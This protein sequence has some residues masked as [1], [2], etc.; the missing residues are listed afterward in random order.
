[1]ENFQSLLFQTSMETYLQSHI[2]T[3]IQ[4]SVET[5]FQLLIINPCSSSW[6]SFFASGDFF[7]GFYED[8]LS[9]VYGVILSIASRELLSI[10]EH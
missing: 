7:S 3:S 1:M 10:L 4:K 9:V 5:Y 2:E 8:G 6:G